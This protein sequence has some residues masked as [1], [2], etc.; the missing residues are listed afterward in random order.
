MHP[1]FAHLPRRLETRGAMGPGF[2]R[3]DDIGEQG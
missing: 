1:R 2:R 3:D